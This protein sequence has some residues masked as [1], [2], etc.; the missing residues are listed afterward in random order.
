MDKKEDAPMQGVEQGEDSKHI[1]S[2][3]ERSR[4]EKED[5]KELSQAFSELLIKLKQNATPASTSPLSLLLFF[6]DNSRVFKDVDP[7]KETGLLPNWNIFSGL[8]VATPSCEVHR[9]TGCY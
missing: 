2:L 5:R 1:M 4:Q 3:Q 6:W 9:G 8:S 7:N